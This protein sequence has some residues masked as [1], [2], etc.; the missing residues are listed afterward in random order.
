[1]K[2]NILLVGESWVSAV[3]HFKGFDTFT[4][5]SSAVGIKPLAAV[6]AML[7]H[8]ADVVVHGAVG[9]VAIQAQR[10]CQNIALAEAGGGA[11]LLLQAEVERLQRQCW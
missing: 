7:L 8:Q 6:A 1:M 5:V 10:R 11:R 2:K 4:T 9:Q 3:N